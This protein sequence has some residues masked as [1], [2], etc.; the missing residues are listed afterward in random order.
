MVKLRGAAQHGRKLAIDVSTFPKDSD[1]NM[2]STS[3]YVSEESA[4]A[5]NVVS[6]IL[7][8]IGQLRAAYFVNQG[9]YKAQ[10]DEAKCGPDGNMMEWTVRVK[11]VGAADASNTLTCTGNDAPTNTDE[12]T[13]GWE[14][15][16]WFDMQGS[17]IQVQTQVFKPV[18]MDAEPFIIPRLNVQFQL[19][20]MQMGPGMSGDMLG[21]L[22]STQSK[23]GETAIQFGQ[24][25]VMNMNGQ[26]MELTQGAIHCDYNTNTGAG[27]VWSQ[28]T[29][30]PGAAPTTFKLAFDG[31][32]V[33][34]V[35]D[36]GSAQVLSC[37]NMTNPKRVGSQYKLYDN[38]GKAVLFEEGF[39][40]EAEKDGKTYEAWAGY[41]GLHV[42]STSGD[43]GEEDTTGKTLFVDGAKVSKINYDADS[44][45]TPYTLKVDNG[46]LMKVSR[47]TVKLGALKGVALNVGHGSD[48][49][50]IMFDGTQLIEVGQRN[51]MCFQ[52]DQNGPPTHVS[53]KTDRF[54][55]MCS[56]RNSGDMWD[57]QGYMWYDDLFKDAATPSPFTVTTKAFP[58]GIDVSAGSGSARFHGRMKLEIDEVLKMGIQTS[59]AFVKGQNVTQGSAVG[60][61]YKTTEASFGSATIH[62]YAAYDRLNKDCSGTLSEISMWCSH[63]PTGA[64]LTQPATGATGVIVEGGCLEYTV[65]FEATSGTFST[66]DYIIA[67]DPTELTGYFQWMQLSGNFTPSSVAQSSETLTIKV[68]SGAFTES[69]YNSV[70]NTWVQ[71]PDVYVAGINHNSLYWMHRERGDLKHQPD[72]NTVIT[73]TTR[74]LVFPSDT[75]PELVCYDRC[76]K[77]SDITTCSGDACYENEPGILTA[78]VDSAGNGCVQANLEFTITKN[79][80]TY[81]GASI[82]GSVDSSNTLRSVEVTGRGDGCTGGSD[83]SI[84]ITVSGCTSAPT[85]EAYCETGTDDSASYGQA[86]QYAFDG[87]DLKDKSGNSVSAA[88][89]PD[90]GGI[91]SGILFE[92]TDA[93][94]TA[95]KCDYDDKRVC[96]HDLREKLSTYY[97]WETRQSWSTRI[98]LVDV[99]TTPATVVKFDQPISVSYTH[100]G[101]ESNSGKNYKGARILMSYENELRGFPEFCIDKETLEKTACAPEWSGI[102]RNVPDFK[103]PYDA[104]FENTDTGDEYVAKAGEIEQIMEKASNMSYCANLDTTNVPAPVTKDLFVAFDIGAKPDLK[105][106]PTVVY[107]GV[108]LAELE[109][110]EEAADNE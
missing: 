95:G 27:K 83:E 36:D 75:V 22:F 15:D 76:P 4:E 10:V 40:I 48:A 9:P 2:A 32:L 35:K 21:L 7:C 108:L 23:T 89:T 25:M 47:K 33:K 100:S 34:K 85:V 109:A 30:Q 67:S 88:P 42:H 104:I 81:P 38:K 71:S 105:N 50:R 62:S 96:Y 5:L 69:Y 3:V 53:G 101:T 84:S 90:V 78:R 37:M 60:E 107:S 77:A 43:D 110:I 49:K 45:R 29:S 58:W 106:S 28:T 68:I 59:G 99:T 17:G 14:I 51:G 94:K 92:L 103:I 61:V 56:G 46:R 87:Y 13:C 65:A 72:A 24:F 26:T 97:E 70:T 80:E 6:M 41:H 18:D 16:V 66:N 63:V 52:Y 8:D 86:K 11:T 93:A 91:H 20:N 1:Y 57:S 82:K 31:A 12:L 74:K 44:S 54:S 39:P 79:S 55:C 19:K 73:Y 98:S 64:I 102:T